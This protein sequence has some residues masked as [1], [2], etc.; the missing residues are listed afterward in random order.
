MKSNDLRF[1]DVS[2]TGTPDTRS[3]G[4][5]SDRKIVYDAYQDSV[6]LLWHSLS[7]E[8]QNGFQSLCLQLPDN[9]MATK[10][11]D[12]VKVS[13]FFLFSSMNHAA[14]NSGAAS[15][16]TVPPAT[17]EYAQPL[18]DTLRLVSAR[19]GSGQWSLRLI[20][21][22]YAHSVA[23]Y[24]APAV[25]SGT[26]TYK[27]GSLA[28]AGPLP[29]GIPIG[30][31]DITQMFLSLYP[32]APQNGQKVAVQIMGVTPSGFHTAKMFLESIT[33]PDLTEAAGT[34]DDTQGTETPADGTLHVV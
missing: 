12:R 9:R 23:V 14:R 2:L 17:L 16:I 4:Q 22:V 7:A 6:R 1:R 5:G 29:G 18:P 27:R 10:L 34:G 20:G 19:T 3:Q 11:G 8:A 33:G 24:M 30:G 15:T 28:K 32:V 21:G 26:N 13:A 25:M 31:A